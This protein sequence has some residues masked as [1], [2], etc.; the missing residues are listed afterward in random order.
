MA[1]EKLNTGP[2]EVVKDDPGGGVGGPGDVE[3]SAEQI[4]ELMAAQ[5]AAEASS[6]PKLNSWI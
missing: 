2:E 4:E 6:L 3:V 1:E 5:K